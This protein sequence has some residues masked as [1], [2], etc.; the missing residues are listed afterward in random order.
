MELSE[1]EPHGRKSGRGGMALKMTVLQ[2]SF[3]ANFCHP[4]QP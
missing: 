2:L 3:K 1:M 4:S